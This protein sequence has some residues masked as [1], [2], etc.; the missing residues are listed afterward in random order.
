MGSPTISSKSHNDTSI[1]SAFFKNNFKKKTDDVKSLS[2]SEPASTITTAADF[3]APCSSKAIPCSS[4]AIPCSSKAIPCSSKAINIEHDNTFSIYDVGTYYN[5]VKDLSDKE[6][7]D[8]IK[9]VF[10]PDKSFKFLKDKDNRNFRHVWLE[11]FPWLCYSPGKKGAFCLQCTLFGMKVPNR[12]NKAT[13]LISTAQNHWSDSVHTFKKHQSKSALHKHTSLILTQFLSDASGKTQLIDQII[14]SAR[15]KKLEKNRK[16]LVPIV[17][18]VIFCGRRGITFRG[19]RDDFKY[20]PEVGEYSTGQVGNFV[21]LLNYRVRS[22]DKLLEEHLRG[23]PKNASYISKTT[24]NELISCCGGFI[25]EKI[26]SEVKRNKFFTIICD[27]ASDSSNKE[28]MSMV[29]RFVDDN[30]NIR[31][32]FINFIHCKEGLTGANLASIILKSLE[33]HSLEIQNCRGQCYDGAGAVSGKV[34]GC[35]AHIL[36]LNEKALYTHCFSHRLNLVVCTSCAVVSVRNTLDHIKDIS[37][38]FNLSQPRQQCLEKIINEICP[39]TKKTK[40]KDVCRTR[41]LERIDGLDTF[42]ELFVAIV[43][44]FEDMT[45]N[46]KCNRDTSTKAS[47]FLKLVTSFDFIV[48]MVLTR[49]VFDMTLDVTQMLQSRNNDILDAVHMVNT[50]KNHFSSVRL[51]IDKYHA[52]WYKIALALAEEVNVK[53][54]KPRT[55]R[56]QTNRANTPA[57][58][59]SEYFKR[60]V[61]IP[62]VDHVNTQL[63]QRFDT[64]LTAYHGLVIIPTKMIFCIQREQEGCAKLPWRQQMQTFARFYEDDLPNPLSLDAELDLWET[65]WVTYT[66]CHPNSV[67]QTLKAMPHGVFPNIEVAL[68]ILAT[69][70]VTSCE[71]ERSFSALRRLKDY[72]RSTMLEN[73]LNGLALMY[74]HKEILPDIEEVIQQFSLMGPRKLEFI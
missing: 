7:L 1:V 62:L 49:N 24:Q 53:E 27:E 60:N 36:R 19:H 17:D 73:R 71:C 32:D 39:D 34:N 14:N 30:F 59:V 42:E 54:S 58:D 8:L 10:V 35:S 50:L 21:K 9:N 26:I 2:I 57:D 61:T 11:M 56:H 65:Y 66:G 18:T 43:N 64:S 55:C 31:E 47:A 68:R 22:G 41:W 29:L 48:P 33:E 52:K 45:S 23:C 51:Q 25:S 20:H 12:T 69:L 38:F 3:S 44:T 28:Q 15:K 40:L 74:V 4:K 5:K 6:I 13:N 63:A 46:I 16:V 37:Y 67:G 72:S 70:P